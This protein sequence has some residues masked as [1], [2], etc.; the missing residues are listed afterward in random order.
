M[1]QNEL[2]AAERV[3]DAMIRY[4][5]HMVHNRPGMVVADNTP[6]GVQWFPVTHKVENDRKVV[7]R[8]DEHRITKGKGKGKKKVIRTRVGIMRDN[9]GIFDG[10]R[11]VAEYRKPGLFPEVI[12][13]AYQQIADI[14]SL[15]NE[16]AARWASHAFKGEHKDLKALL[17]A[18]MLVQSRKGVPEYEDGKVAFYDEDYRDVGEAMMLIYSKPSKGKANISLDAKLLLR[19]HEFLSVPGVVEINRKL[20]FANSARKKNILGRWP[21]AVRKWLRYRENNPKMLE[22]LVKSGQKHKVM[23]LAQLS[24]Y[25]PESDEFFKTLGWKQKQAADGRRQVAIG[26]A[27]KGATAVSF[28]GKTEEE[29][30]KAIIDTKPSFK[31]IS[32]TVPGGLTPAIVAAAIEAGSL[33][34]KELV[35]HTPTLEE[36]GLLKVP[37]I[38]AKWEQALKSA[39]DMRAANIARNIQSKATRQKMEAASEEVAQKAVEEVIRDVRIYIMVDISSS[40]MNAIERAKALIERFLPAFPMDKIHVSVFNTAGRVVEIKVRS[41]AGVRNAFKGI[42]AGG[43]TN[44]GAGVLVLKRFAPQPNED[45]LFIFVGDEEAGTF[46]EAVQASGL[47]PMSFGFLKVRNSPGYRAVQDTARQLGVP[48]FM[49]DDKTFDD[50]YAIPRTIRTLVAAT[51]VGQIKEGQQVRFALV[52]QIQQTELLKKPVWATA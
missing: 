45:V 14:W 17:A 6:V 36:L 8:L 39:E 21:A 51:P 46:T 31:V 32:G 13:W 15:D 5:D 10:N 42:K 23:R 20:G 34:S 7:Y 2:G 33:S 48:C 50:V 12:V 28:E 18:F 1:E 27:I 41:A 4:T 16:F 35:I 43:G 19:I 29:I 37:E 52:E 3:L 9:G 40:M 22:G 11:K 49:I 24:G 25:K 44:Y 26:Q 30:C 47:R 38:L